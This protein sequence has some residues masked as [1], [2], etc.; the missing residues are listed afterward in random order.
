MESWVQGRPALVNGRSPVL[1]QHAQAS[2][3]GLP[4]CGFADFA[5]CLDYLIEH[6]EV[7]GRMGE[8]GRRYVDANFRWDCMVERYAGL[9]G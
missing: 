6:P 7:G 4:F 2:G 9:L 1:A 3:G 5:G 8:A